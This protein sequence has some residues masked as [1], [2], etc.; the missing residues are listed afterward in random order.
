MTN[1]QVMNGIAGGP[2]LGMFLLG[3]LTRR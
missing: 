1:T 2:L 3:I